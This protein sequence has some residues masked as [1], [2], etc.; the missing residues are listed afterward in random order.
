MK[1]LLCLLATIFTISVYAQSNS[2]KKAL[3]GTWKIQLVSYDD[4]YYYDMTEDKFVVGEKLAKLMQQD[5]ARYG[6]EFLETLKKQASAY[7]RQCSFIIKGNNTYSLSMGTKKESGNFSFL[8]LQ[9]PISSESPESDREYN[10]INE[11]YLAYLKLNND[12][13]ISIREYA[14][15]VQVYIY[16]GAK[17][18]GSDSFYASVSFFLNKS[19]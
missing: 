12:K 4:Y 18:S 3:V 11:E 10:E 7:A 14:D 19:N 13:T 9:I 15:A 2:E 6:K 8:P 16:N 5:S 17:K 1:Q